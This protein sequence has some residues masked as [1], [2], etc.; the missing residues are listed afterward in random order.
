[1]P[2]IDPVLRAEVH[3]AVREDQK[4]E[5][6][7]AWERWLPTARAFIRDPRNRSAVLAETRHLL[8]QA[9]RSGRN[10]FT[11]DEVA[12]LYARDRDLQAYVQNP[13]ANVRD[14]GPA[15]VHVDTLMSQMSVRFS[16]PDYIGEQLAEPFQVDKESNL[17]AFYDERG[18][19]AFP[20]NTAGSR[21]EIPEVN[22]GINITDHNYKC[23]PLGMKALVTPREISN[24]DVPLDPMVDHLLLVMEGNAWNREVSDAAFYTSTSNYA[25]AN[26]TAINAGE[27]YDS[28]GGGN[29]NKQIQD[30][31]IRVFRARGATKRIGAMSIDT[32]TVLSRHPAI[33]D[34]FKYT[35]DGFA[36][37]Q[38]LA[39]YYGLDDLL[40][41]EAWKDTANS[42]QTANYGRIWNDSI[43]IIC[44]NPGLG[45]RSYSH[46]KRF[47]KGALKNE[48]IFVPQDGFEG[49]YTIRETYM[50]TVV[51]VAPRAGSLLTNALSS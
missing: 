47:R 2:R 14:L 19:L 21:G 39:R 46:S 27:E 42:G 43:V 22:Q 44:Q 26:I 10:I 28:S 17:F 31:V 49:V 16:N 13:A 5:K 3:A 32:F 33:R 9:I 48:T 30:A 36:S 7:R 37:R 15:A 11:E 18:N 29:P 8:A 45:V 25:A 34:L 40:V 12:Q 20:S 38:Q 23:L 4:T 50:E 41:G 51:S 24:A 6:A 1:M 35:A